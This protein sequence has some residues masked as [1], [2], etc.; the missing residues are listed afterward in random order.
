M[1]DSHQRQTD[2]ETKEIPWIFLI[3]AVIFS[4]CGFVD[5]SAGDAD[6]S[7]IWWA[8]ALGCFAGFLAS[9]YLES[10]KEERT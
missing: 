1:T 4:L 7:T 3:F 9:G 6:G 10:K 2:D 5:D 8:L